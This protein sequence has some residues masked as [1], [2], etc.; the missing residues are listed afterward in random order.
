MAWGGERVLERVQGYRMVKG[1]KM[2]VCLY[3]REVWGCGF[4][5]RM[6]DGRMKGGVG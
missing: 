3:R 2:G 5:I 1:P 4:W 6:T